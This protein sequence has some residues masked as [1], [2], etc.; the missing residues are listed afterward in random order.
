MKISNQSRGNWSSAGVLVRAAGALDNDASNDNFLTAHSFRTNSGG[1]L[2]NTVQLANVIGGSE[3][4]TNVPVSEA[5]LAYLRLVH[6]GNGEFEVF[7]STDGNNW[8][9]RNEVVNAEL[10]SG[11][12]EVGLWAGSYGGG[13]NTGNAQFDWAQII[14]GVPAGDFNN[15]GA[16]NAADYT[17]WRDT[18]GSNVTA[19]SGADGNGDGLV[20]GVDYD[21]WQQNFGKTI[22]NLGGA[23]GA[24]TVP[25]PTGWALIV[26]CASALPWGWR[27]NRGVRAR[28][29]PL[30]LDRTRR[31]RW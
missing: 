8:V 12:L 20:N 5:D 21:V 17:V 24:A 18:A 25:E 16:I 31:M 29:F 27:R 11:L 13:I 4:E 23:G 3:G 7:S 10:A 2:A 15:D 14:V 9:S 26:A 1:D 30:S 6:H 22:P 28:G 19:W